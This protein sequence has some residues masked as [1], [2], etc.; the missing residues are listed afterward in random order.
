VKEASKQKLLKSK[1]VGKG[2]KNL[3]FKNWG[4]SKQDK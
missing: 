2:V 3:Y 1:K 4:F